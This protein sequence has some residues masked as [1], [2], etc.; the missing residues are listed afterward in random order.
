MAGLSEK[1]YNKSCTPSG[2]KM[3]SVNE[4]VRCGRQLE[5]D[6]IYILLFNRIYPCERAKLY[7]IRSAERVNSVTV[8]AVRKYLEH[9]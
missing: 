8:A 1:E 5:W 3:R 4:T 9:K 6:I 2:G 7:T